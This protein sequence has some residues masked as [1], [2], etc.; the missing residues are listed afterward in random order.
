MA[1]VG[2]HSA[3]LLNLS[4]RFVSYHWYFQGATRLGASR[5]TTYID[6]TGRVRK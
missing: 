5:L 6:Q 1:Y 4:A 2:T 3:R